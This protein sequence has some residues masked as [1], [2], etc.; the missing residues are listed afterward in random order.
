[1]KTAVS[2]WTHY[3]GVV[4]GT[5]K[6]NV[7]HQLHQLSSQAC[8]HKTYQS[9]ALIVATHFSVCSDVHTD[10]KACQYKASTGTVAEISVELSKIGD[11]CHLFIK[12]SFI[13]FPLFLIILILIPF[14]VYI[15]AD[16][17]YLY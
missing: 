3:P 9:S 2:F 11:G 5:Q 13:I 1:M 14:I 10:V 17:L 16:T 8:H 15:I 6:T 12:Y 4:P 7:R